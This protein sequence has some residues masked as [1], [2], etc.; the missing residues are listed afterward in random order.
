M[1]YGMLLAYKRRSQDSTQ[2]KIFMAF[3]SSTSTL[4]GSRTMSY[5]NPHIGHIN[6]IALRKDMVERTIGELHLCV[7]TTYDTDSTISQFEDQWQG[8]TLA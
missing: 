6:E 7:W 1:P 5:H 8:I 2:L 4:E 3:V